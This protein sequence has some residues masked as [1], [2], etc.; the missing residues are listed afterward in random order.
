MYFVPFMFQGVIST[1]ILLALILLLIGIVFVLGRFFLHIIYQFIANSVL[2]LVSLF[3]INYFFGVA[4]TLSIPVIIFVAVFGLPAVFI[5]V[6][7]K[8]VLGWSV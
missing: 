7:L 5:L 3:A 6:F 8:L 2:G 1:V 4:I